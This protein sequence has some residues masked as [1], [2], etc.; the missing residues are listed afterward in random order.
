M[1]SK[2]ISTIKIYTDG[3]LIKQQVSNKTGSGIFISQNNCTINQMALTLDC[4]STVFQC[5]MF[6]ILK[7]AE[8]LNTNIEHETVYILSDSQAA[9]AALQKEYTKSS[10][11]LNTIGELNKASY[12]NNINLIKVPAHIGIAGNELAD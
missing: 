6:A 8:W 10:L 12:T 4:N 1:N 7:A 2:I 5:E 9:L 3:S 11:V